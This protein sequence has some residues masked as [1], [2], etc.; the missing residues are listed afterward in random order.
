M[1]SMSW[2]CAR[3]GA[4]RSGQLPVARLLV[5]LVLSPSAQA[6][7][8]VQ[9]SADDAATR[10]ANQNLRGAARRARGDMGR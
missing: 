1:T 2:S 5:A 4:L 3:G 9:P 7:Q 6:P 8:V 10:H